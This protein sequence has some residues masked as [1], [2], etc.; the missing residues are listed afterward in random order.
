M[1]DSVAKD[2]DLTNQGA[3][4]RY[5]RSQGLITGYGGRKIKTPEVG[6]R[7]NAYC[8]ILSPEGKKRLLAA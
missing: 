6:D 4:A 3:L 1:L 8:Y 5:L 2:Y 7:Q